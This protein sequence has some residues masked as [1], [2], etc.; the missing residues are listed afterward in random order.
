MVTTAI[1]CNHSKWPNVYN[2]KITVTTHDIGGLPQCDVNFPVCRLGFRA[3]KKSETGHDTVEITKH[4]AAAREAGWPEADRLDH[5]T[6]TGRTILPT[7]YAVWQQRLAIY[8]GLLSHSYKA[9]L[10]SPGLSVLKRPGRKLFPR[11]QQTPE[12]LGALVKG[13]CPRQV[14]ST[15]DSGGCG[16]AANRR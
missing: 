3:S 2:V 11:D 8:G 10:P 12:R 15:S 16:G 14:R 5:G 1:I 6:G 13:Q 4:G 7:S 9:R